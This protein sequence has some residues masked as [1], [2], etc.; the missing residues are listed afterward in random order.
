MD[1]WSAIRT[2]RHWTVD[3]LLP[4]NGVLGN[5]RIEVAD[6]ATLQELAR[7]ESSKGCSCCLNS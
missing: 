2:F 4:E 7:L 5:Y 6:N 3:S 1:V